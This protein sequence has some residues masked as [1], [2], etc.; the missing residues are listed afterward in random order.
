MRAMSRA[1]MPRG[2]AAYSDPTLHLKCDRQAEEI[3]RAFWNDVADG[4][5][6]LRSSRGSPRGRRTAHLA[7]GDAC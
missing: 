6:C 4:A 5:T 3:L 1:A 2:A 7:S